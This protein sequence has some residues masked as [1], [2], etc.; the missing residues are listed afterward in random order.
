[1][2]EFLRY[3]GQ[4]DTRDPVHADK[5]SGEV[6]A[7][8]ES[9]RL[10]SVCTSPYGYPAEWSTPMT[11]CPV[12]TGEIAG[13]VRIAANERV[14]SQNLDILSKAFNL[15]MTDGEGYLGA[16]NHVATSLDLDFRTSATSVLIHMVDGRVYDP[17][18]VGAGLNAIG[19]EFTPPH[20]HAKCPN[21]A[22]DDHSLPSICLGT[23]HRP[24]SPGEIII[25]CDWAERVRREKPKVALRRLIQFTDPETQPF[26][27]RVRDA[28]GP[29]TYAV[30]TDHVRIACT[31]RAVSLARAGLD[32][33]DIPAHAWDAVFF[34][35]WPF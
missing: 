26:M 11:P 14:D 3:K 15:L 4:L 12:T 20:A 2:F 7:L 22:P 35:N 13:L 19:V 10:I 18:P 6:E 17:A 25:S 30:L 9:L 31:I 24:A 33:R 27:H 16:S 5:R 34:G 21:A 1:M 32:A 23:Y 29:G 8:M 28:F